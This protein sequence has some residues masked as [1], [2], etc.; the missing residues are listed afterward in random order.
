MSTPYRSP[1]ADLGRQDHKP[2]Q[3]AIVRWV[4][5]VILIF[6]VLRSLLGFLY[7]ANL[8][9]NYSQDFRF[10]T[11]DSLM[12]LTQWL[13]DMG[14]MVLSLLGLFKQKRFGWIAAVV[15][16]VISLGQALVWIV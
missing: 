4:L 6:D 9:L 15:Y 16:L 13:F 1:E 10:A 12:F 5:I 14:L 7:T 8:T 3:L 11:A 2:K